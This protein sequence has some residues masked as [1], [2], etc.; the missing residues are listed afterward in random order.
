MNTDSYATKLCLGALAGL[1]GAI[2]IKGG[3]VAAQRWAPQM[4]PP[5]KE[6]PGEFMVRKA[7]E[8]LPERAKVKIPDAAETAAAQV[9]GLGYGVTFGILYSALPRKQRKMAMDGT[10]LGLGTWAAGYLGWLPAIGL[11]PPVWKQKPKQV[12]PNILSHALFGVITV[13]ALRELEDRL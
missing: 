9:L 11:M 6:D 10:L 4:L 12:L 13:A 8:A 7:E 3:M 2:F 1:A 5:I